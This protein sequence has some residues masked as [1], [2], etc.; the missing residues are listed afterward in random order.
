MSP[1]TVRTPQQLAQLLQQQRRK[2]G[3]TQDDLGKS[4]GLLPKTISLLENHAERSK[5]STLFRLCA[6]LGVEIVIQE[7]VGKPGLQDG[8]TATH[9][10]TE[11]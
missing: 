6:A 7:K 3:L 11:W 4:F 1:S 2:L 5:I 9:A 10:E 8:P